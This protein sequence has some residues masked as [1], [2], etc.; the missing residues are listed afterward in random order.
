MKTF[1]RHAVTLLAIAVACQAGL[2]LADDGYYWVSGSNQSAAPAGTEKVAAQGQSACSSCCPDQSCNACDPCGGCLGC[3]SGER[4][5]IVGTFGLD[6]FKGVS[7]Q[8]YNS[9]F[10]AVT[11]L[12]SGLLLPVARLRSRLADRPSATAFTIL[13]AESTNTA[14]PSHC[15]QQLF[16][17]TGFYHKAKCDQR[18]SFGLV[19]DWMYNTDWGF[20][21]TNPTLGQWR[22]QV[23]YAVND[24]NGIGLWAPRTILA[25]R[26]SPSIMIPDSSSPIVRSAGQ[27]VLAPQVRLH[28]RRQLAVVGVPITSGSTNR[29]ADGRRQP[30]RLDRWRQLAGTLSERLALYANGSSCI[31][32]PPRATWLPRKPAGT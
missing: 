30:R 24:C 27:P 3:E 26:S 17:T 28:V 4:Y 9:N 29:H 13:T 21:G 19:Y 5:G 25:P 20:Y 14:D 6:A 1:V 10:G 12:N 8:F 18:L 22:A 31:P 11:G 15:Q 7:D 32:A 2:A 16:V 23:E